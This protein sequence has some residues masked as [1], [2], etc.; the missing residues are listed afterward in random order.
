MTSN[1]DKSIEECLQLL[2][3]QL[4]H[5]QHDLNSELRS[6]KFIHN[7]LINACQD[8]F[9]CQYACFKSSDFL[10]DLINHLRSSIIIYQKSIHQ[11]SSK[12]LKHSSSIDDIIRIFHSES[13]IFRESIR[14]VAISIFR[15][16]NVSSV[17]KK[18]VDQ[19]NIQKKNAKLLS[20]SSKFA[21]SI[22]WISEFINTSSSTKRRI[23]HLL[24]QKTILI[25][26]WTKWRR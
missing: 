11:I 5:L 22:R 23:H 9:V 26:I 1:E 24:I 14:I 13:T 4:R 3:K 17:I 8:V 25:L 21:F 12:R 7:K 2:I 18:N 20:K 15:R 6:E 10:I 19:S 16:R